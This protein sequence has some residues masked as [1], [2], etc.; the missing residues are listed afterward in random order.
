M[1]SPSRTFGELGFDA[2]GAACGLAVIA[3]ALAV[4]VA[5]FD[6][7]TATLVSL[8][9]AGWASLHRPGRQHRPAPERGNGWETHVL[10]FVLLAAAAAVFFDPQAP[11]GPWRALILGLGVVPLW[12][13]ERRSPNAPVTGRAR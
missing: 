12:A 4:L 11:V 5:T 7:L 6:I 13:R 10:P 1:R 3:G 2:F 8:A 9:L